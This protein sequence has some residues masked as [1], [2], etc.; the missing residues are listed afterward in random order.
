MWSARS[1]MNK[2]IFRAILALALP[3]AFADITDKTL[4]IPIGSS[5]DMETGAIVSSGGDL[6]WDGITLTPQGG[7]KAAYIGPG[8]DLY[9]AQNQQTLQ[10]SAGSIVNTLPIPVGA[11]TGGSVLAVLTTAGHWAKLEVTTTSTPINSPLPIKFTTYGAGGGGSTTPTITKVTNNYSYI[12]SGFPNSGISPSTIFTIF[13]S[14]LAVAPTGTVSLNS[15]A[16][17]GL[18][19]I[20]AGTSV[21]VTVGGKTVTPGLYYALPTQI[22]GVLPAGTPAGTGTITV[23]YNNATSSAFSI[24]VVPAAL[25]LDTYYGTGSGLITATDAVSGALMSYTNSAKPNQNIVLWGSGLGADP[26]DSDTVFTSSPHAVN[27]GS[28]H[29]YIGGTEATVLY[30]GS[31]GYPGL[32]Q[33]NVTVPSNASSGCGVSLVGVVNGVTSNFGSLPIAP[34]GG[35]CSDSAF[36]ITGAGLSQLNGQTTVKSGATFVGQMTASGVTQNLAAASFASYT[37]A[38]YGSGTF[39]SIGSCIVSQSPSGGGGG[40]S[41]GLDAGTLSLTGPAGSYSLMSLRKGS[42]VAQLPSSAITSSGGSFVFNGGGG[43]DVG[44]LMSTIN[45]PNPLLNWTN[46]IAAASVNRANGLLV[47][48]TGGGVGTWVLI[49]GSSSASN[50]PDGSF[51]CYAPVSAGQFQVPAYVTGTL[52]AGTGSVIVENS[53]SFTPFTATGLDVAYGFGFSGA[54]VDSTWQ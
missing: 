9:Q 53:T 42:Y 5:V 35:A 45:L 11:L 17:S 20:Q 23:T 8:D 37:G 43:A 24:Q 10:S 28:T 3:A 22:A 41:T 16:G 19:T 21:S 50:G 32:V 46:Q 29:I 27:Q 47:T 1:H 15:S 48:W 13:G 40:T 12:P 4:T 14:N 6:K 18:P 49:S 31:S 26:Q 2:Q 25:G 33:I 51:T 36:G 30:A 44:A 39:I 38:S 54:T 34:A 7:A 52:P